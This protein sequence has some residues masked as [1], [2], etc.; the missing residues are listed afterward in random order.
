MY[1]LGILKN[2]EVKNGSGAKISLPVLPVAVEWWTFGRI[3]CLNEEHFIS[4]AL[5]L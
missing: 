4:R 3:E 2:L 5:G 1:F